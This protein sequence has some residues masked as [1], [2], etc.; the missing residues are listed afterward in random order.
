MA[1]QRPT[2][3]LQVDRVVRLAHC[4]SHGRL[5]PKSSDVH[6]HILAMTQDMRCPRR[7]ALT[8]DRKKSTDSCS[9]LPHEAA[10]QSKPWAEG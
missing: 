3:G 1:D 9:P 8:R 4:H 7:G 2:E 5:D 6:V 10:G